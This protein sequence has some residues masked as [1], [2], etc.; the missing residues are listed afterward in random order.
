LRYRY[1]GQVYR[2][3]VEEPLKAWQ[4]VRYLGH[5]IGR[6]VES[7]I[8]EGAEILSLR[9]AYDTNVGR[10]DFFEIDADNPDVYQATHGE[11]IEA[12]KVMNRA[13]YFDLTKGLFRS[14]KLVEVNQAIQ[15]QRYR[16]SFSKDRIHYESIMY[17]GQ[18]RY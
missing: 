1:A 7:Y 18:H 13:R 16:E 2:L 14:G 5:S 6:R 15:Q 8:P 9:A 10:Y 17:M 12:I 3:L 4:K 11:E